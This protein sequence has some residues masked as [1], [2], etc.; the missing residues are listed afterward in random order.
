MPLLSEWLQLMLGEI[1]RKRE[2]QERACEE[3]V[4]RNEEQA[5]ESTSSVETPDPTQPPHR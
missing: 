4:R 5:S 1:A 2:E 3:H